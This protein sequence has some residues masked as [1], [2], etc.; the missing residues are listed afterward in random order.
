MKYGLLFLI[1]VVCIQVMGQSNDPIKQVNLQ[2]FVVSA[3]KEKPFEQTSVNILAI[4]L[5]SLR[6]GNFNLTDL[7]AKTPGI[8]M[9]ST[10]VAIAKPVIRGLYGN[11]VLVLL[12]GLKFDNQQWQEEHGLGLSDLGLSKVELIKGP[13][14]VLYGTEAIGGIINLIEEEKPV[15]GTR[16]TDYSVKVNSNTMGGMIQAGYK[17]NF[18]KHWWRIRAGVENNADYSDGNNHRVLNSRFDG[19]DLKATYGFQ[20]RSWASTNNYL[21]SFN[22]YGFIFNDIYSFVTPDERWSRKL[23]VNPAHMVLLN[24]LS[25]ENK[26][27]LKNESKLNLNIGIQSN[28]RMENEGGGAISLNMH[29]LTLQYLLKWEVQVSERNKLVLSNLGSFEDNTNFGA[30]KI[31]PDANMQESNISAFME[32]TLAKDLILEY[33]LGIGEKYIKTFFTATVNG[34]DKEV[35]PFTK[36]SPYYNFVS[37]ITWFPSTDFNMKLNAA[38]GVRIPNLAELSSNGLH[39]GVFIYEVGDP[40]LKNE[41]NITLNLFVNYIQEFFELSVSPFYNY[42]YNYVYLAPIPIDL[43]NWYGFHVSRYRQQ[44]AKQFGTEATFTLKPV[45]YLRTGLAY[46]GM[47]SKT[48]DGAYIPYT[49]A[50]KLEGNFG[51]VLHTDKFNPISLSTDVDYYFAQNDT[52]V[53]EI[54]TP[55]YWIW[56]I[57][58]S[59]TCKSKLA[60]YTFSLSGN[61]LL[62]TAYYDHLSRFKYFK[63]ADGQKILNIGRNFAFSIKVRFNSRINKH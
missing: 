1:L 28:K 59:T 9:L 21:G 24:I 35:H 63:D 51:Y 60:D 20:H 23:D 7:V 34:P 33:G 8:S 42:F 52:A 4:R 6:S 53:G 5:D 17:A 50:Q 27:L 10:G 12:S 37:G 15:S 31:V 32:T 38:T 2:P 22:R 49:P 47:K 57:G 54:S 55:D 39:E 19:Y 13:L 58:A 56:N 45:K 3:Y 48:T 46:S 62:N 18:G 11:R 25:S 36:K 14:S 30:R 61:N 40:N 16:E 44:D 41:Q 43:E 29:L 26:F